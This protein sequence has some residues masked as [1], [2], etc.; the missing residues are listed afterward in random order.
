MHR[1]EWRRAAWIA[2]EFLFRGVGCCFGMWVKSCV[3]M[4]REVLMRAPDTRLLVRLILTHTTC[5]IRSHTTRIGTIGTEARRSKA[6]MSWCRFLR[7][8]YR[9]CSR[10]SSNSRSARPRSS[11]T[12]MHSIRALHSTPSS[13]KLRPASMWGCSVRCGN[14]SNGTPARSSCGPTRSKV[15]TRMHSVGDGTDLDC[16]S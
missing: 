1:A 12:H 15:L 3:L 14:P 10:C 2:A 11:G 5:L 6:R 8:C 9:C 13:P 7:R 16:T 4:Q